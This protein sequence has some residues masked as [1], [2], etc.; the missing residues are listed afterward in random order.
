[1][2]GSRLEEPIDQVVAVHSRNCLEFLFSFCSFYQLLFLSS[3][4]KTLSNLGATMGCMLALGHGILLEVL[5]QGEFEPS[6]SSAGQLIVH[7][8]RK[9]FSNPILGLTFCAILLISTCFNMFQTWHV[10]HA[11]SMAISQYFPVPIS[12]Q[13]HVARLWHHRKSRS[14]A[15]RV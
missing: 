11:I 5:V 4:S 2:A 6:L 15:A 1:M 9:P 12:I 14:A 3:S 7:S 13:K 10:F 8:A